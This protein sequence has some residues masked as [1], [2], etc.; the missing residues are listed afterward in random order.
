M[1]DVMDGISSLPM[2]VMYPTTEIER[3]EKIG[4]YV[5]DLAVSAPLLCGKYPLI[6][7]SHG[8]GGTPLVYRSLAHYLAQHGCI[9]GLPEHAHNNRNDNSLEG[10]LENLTNRP[11]HISLAISWFFDSLN[12]SDAIATESVTIIGHSLGGYTALALAGGLPTCFPKESP[13]GMS[14]RIQVHRDHRVNRLVLLAPATVWYSDTTSLMAIES[15][16]LMLVGQKDEFTPSQI[17]AHIVL[18]GISDRHLVQFSL[19]ENAG[20]YSFLSPFPAHMCHEKFLPSQDPQGFDRVAFQVAMHADIL[21][22]ITA[23]AG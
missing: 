3:A 12:F 10:T 17:H 7:I 21:A 14:R 9:V 23:D 11:R 15:P 16:I 19:I 20:H 4:P 22:F 1:V 6:V 13:D 5:M 18:N 2:M 8:T